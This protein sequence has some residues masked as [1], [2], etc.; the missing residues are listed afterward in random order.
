MS[1]IESSVLEAAM[2]WACALEAQAEAEE[3]LPL[4]TEAAFRLA[5]V[6]LY[7]AILIMRRR[8]AEDAG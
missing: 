4:H 2:N 5:E 8:S 3:A 1:V 6:E 7:T